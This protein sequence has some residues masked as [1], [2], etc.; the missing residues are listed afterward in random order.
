MP[1]RQRKFALVQVEVGGAA[2]LCGGPEVEGR[3]L[4]PIKADGC[5]ARWVVEK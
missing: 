2:G 1:N 5:D 3:G 4:A